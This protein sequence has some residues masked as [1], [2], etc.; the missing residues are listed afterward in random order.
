MSDYKKEVLEVLANS[1]LQLIVGGK[2]PL[3][4]VVGHLSNGC[5]DVRR[6]LIGPVNGEVLVWAANFVKPA[7]YPLNSM[8]NEPTHMRFS[9]HG[10]PYQVDVYRSRGDLPVLAKDGYV[11]FNF[12]SLKSG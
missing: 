7:R 10:S 12:G 5:S 2:S 11:E 8:T 1:N 9:F 6:V 3:K 4:L